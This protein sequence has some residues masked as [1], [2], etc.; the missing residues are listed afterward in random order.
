MTDRER[1][2]ELIDNYTEPLSARDLHKADFAEN[3]AAY[4]LANGVVA[5]QYIEVGGLPAG[6]VAET[7]RDKIYSVGDALKPIRDDFTGGS[8][9]WLDTELFKEAYNVICMAAHLIDFVDE[10]SERSG[11]NG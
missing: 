6:M 9:V 11:N 8:K 10:L 2:I 7:W 4:L 1:L 3:F 5:P